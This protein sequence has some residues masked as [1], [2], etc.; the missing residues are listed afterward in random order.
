MKSLRAYQTELDP[1]KVQRTA[2]LRHAGAARWA[3]NW[4][5][6]QKKAAREAGKPMPTAIDLHR[7]LNA[8]KKTECSWLYQASKCAPQAALRHLDQAFQHFFR[9]CRSGAKKKGYP[10]FKSRKRDG[11][12]SFT[13]YGS[14]RVTAATVQLPRLGEL[15]LKEHGY[16]PTQHVKILRATV[17][18][19][20]GRWFVALQV[21]VEHPDP[22]PKEGAVLGI[23][24]GVKYL[25]VLSD[26]TVFENPKALDAAQQQL[27][28][29]QRT[30][31]RRCPGSANRRK[32]VR[33]V[34]RLHYRI[35]CIRDDALHQATSAVMA[36]Q[37]SVIGIESLNVAGM[38]KNHC[39]ARSI[40]DAS[41]AELGRQLEYKAKWNGI[42]IV[43]A[44]PWFP[45]SKLCSACGV[46]KAVFE[47]Q[48]RTYTCAECGSSLDRDLNAAINLKH[49]AASSAVAACGAGVRPGWPGNGRRSRNRTPD[50]TSS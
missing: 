39:L 16:L 42:E 22:K 28:R 41:L 21:E 31:A 18:E 11:I 33:R 36:K 48:E 4:G 13:L 26:G 50:R 47:L 1:N 37:P 32:A 44:G 23:D 43:K 20:A 7:Q 10:K 2:L 24:L 34:A 14:I 9:R 38:V 49:M 29:A 30:V 46:V 6:K 25:M 40:A 27:A 19:R 45:S 8:L 12:G 5:L 35:A 17:S 15:R 3:Y